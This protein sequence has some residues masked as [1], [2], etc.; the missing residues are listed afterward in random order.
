MELR[1]LTLDPFQ[2]RA[3]TLV[4]EGRS[5]LVSAPTGTG[6]TIVAD[7]VV[8]QALAE[9]R[10]VIYT[11]PVKAL[12]N[13]KFRDYTRLHGE[14]KVGLVTGDLVIR[15]DAP[16]LVMTTEILRN[17]L[18]DPAGTAEATADLAAV[19]LDEIHFLDDRER[20][21]VWEEV[22][23]YLPTEVRILGLSATLSNLEEFAEWLTEV[24]GEAVHIVKEN[25]RAVPL[26]VAFAN[27]D[28]GLLPP[29]EFERAF[30]R[31]K[32]DDKGKKGHRAHQSGRPRG[33]H[34]RNPDMTTHIDIFKMLG[35]RFAPW[36]YFVYS[37]RLAEQFART[38]G[39]FVRGRLVEGQRAR[40]L[41]AEIDEAI[42]S[43]GRD[44]IDGEL[45]ELYRQGIAFHHAGLHVNLKALVEEL[46][47]KKLIAVLYTTST[48]A[49]GINMP[50]RTVVLDGILRYDGSGLNPLTV[51][52]FM[53]SAG[54]AGRRG[55][56]EQGYVVVRLD[57]EDYARHKPS[58]EAYIEARPERVDSSFN[59]SFN[60]VVSLLHQHPRAKVREIVNRSFLAFR[61]RRQLEAQEE[62]VE[63][64]AADIARLEKAGVA[65]GRG[66]PLRKKGKE[67]KRLQRRSKAREDRA[68]LDFELRRQFLVRV[69]YLG[70]DDAL[71]A[72]AAVLRNVRIEEILTTELVLSGL[73]DGLSPELL[74]GVLCAMTNRF[75]K[76]TH[77]HG[78]PTSA[79]RRIAGEVQALRD[80]E[81]VRGAEDITSLEVNWEP[82]LILFG[83]L[84]A[85][86]KTLPELQL[87]Y[88]TASDISGQLV[89]GFRRAKDLAGQLLDVFRE[90]EH[91]ATMLRQLIRTVS[92]DEV[93][94]LD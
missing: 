63:E 16:C 79:M 92:R 6:K 55:M 89:S 86:G 18:L 25:Q 17:M 56:D 2:A 59:L 67:L 74:F 60:S 39:R 85:Q 61:L 78:R 24:R 19:I 9:G 36:L 76:N 11:A 8:E 13:Q 29:G 81:A 42:H 5:V 23:I 20:G 50:A 77:V 71:L 40:D 87:L 51:R 52:E 35:P 21:T 88:S 82:E 27:T 93:E 90:D 53:Q 41:D 94:V 49:L 64:L 47:E 69:G 32:K 80:S 10:R 34:G 22:L 33:R 43:L 75:P 3:I 68:W 37:R 4:R 65:N 31:W 45:E 1:G 15:R 30:K 38:L 91:T 54:R 12:S 73:L 44:I 48:F 57:F 66:S 28:A 7:V 70:E 84:W 72:G 46:Y 58:L 62:R 83:T 26:D 14:D